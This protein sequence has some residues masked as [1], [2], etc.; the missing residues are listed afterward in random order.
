MQQWKKKNP[1]QLHPY[2]IERYRHYH[3]GKKFVAKAG[4]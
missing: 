2:W 4:E 1:G 3:Q